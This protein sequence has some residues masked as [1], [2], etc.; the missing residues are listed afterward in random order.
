MAASRKREEALHRERL[1]AEIAADKAA[2]RAG[3]GKLPTQLGVDG[4]APS[5]AG[6]TP[7]DAASEAERDARAKADAAAQAKLDAESKML[8]DAAAERAATAA[9]PMALD[10]NPVSAESLARTFGDARIRGGARA[11]AAM[12]EEAIGKIATYSISARARSATIAARGDDHRDG[13]AC[14]KTLGAYVGNLLDHPDEEKFRSINGANAAFLTKVGNLD[15]GVAVLAA[16]GFARGPETQLVMSADALAANR[17]LLVATRKRLAQ[18][19]EA[20]LVAN[21]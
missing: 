3:G 7:V 21:A 17:K 18:A 13:G 20:F 11:A 14:L 19:L 2:R 8:A 9:A 4:Y 5:V 6:T 16:V 12:V 1:R 15:G 10:P